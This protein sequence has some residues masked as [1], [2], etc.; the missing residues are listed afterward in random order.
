MLT[1][2]QKREECIKYETRW[3]LENMTESEFIFLFRHGFEGF[4]NYS[5]EDIEEFYKDNIEPEV[6]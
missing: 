3:A 2:E 6:R 5:D 1:I 4:D